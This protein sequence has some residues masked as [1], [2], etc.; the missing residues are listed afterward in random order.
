MNE[1]YDAA[2][3]FFDFNENGIWDDAEYYNDDNENGEYDPNENF[4]DCGY[5]ANGDGHIDEDEDEYV[6]IEICSENG[7]CEG[8]YGNGIWDDAESYIDTNENEEYDNAE[9]FYDENENGIWDDANGDE[10]CNGHCDNYNEDDDI[11]TWARTF[12]GLGTDYGLSIDKN[13]NETGYIITGSTNSFSENEFDLW[14]IKTDIIG[15]TCDYNYVEE[16]FDF[17]NNDKYDDG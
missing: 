6:C 4:Y 12:G 11:E 17:N 16:Y 10:H 7:F 3:F 2:E 15:N 13:L 8:T 14:L 5:D 1:Q 9:P